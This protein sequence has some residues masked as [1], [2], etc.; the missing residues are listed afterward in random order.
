VTE[1]LDERGRPIFWP[2]DEHGH[3]IVGGAPAV[4][5][6]GYWATGLNLY[7]N[8]GVLTFQGQFPLGDVYHD[9]FS[10]PMGGGPTLVEGIGVVG[11]GL[12]FTATA[13]TLV[14]TGFVAP[15]DPGTIV[16]L[17]SISNIRLKGSVVGTNAPITTG[18]DFF[19]GEDQPLQWTITDE[20]A[21]VDISGYALQF[22]LFAYQGGPTLFT[23]T[24]AITNGPEGICTAQVDAAD[25]SG[26]SGRK[27]YT[28]ART[29]AAHARVYAYG[30][31]ELRAR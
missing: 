4:T 6:E 13:P 7:A 10:A 24:A 8:A 15:T 5:E 20:G 29:D 3:T 19:E 27:W 14:T 31:C 30:F 16:L 18:D 21:I 25:T 23:K 9:S 12:V 28:L 11:G 2:V 17:G 22:K 1:D 26:R